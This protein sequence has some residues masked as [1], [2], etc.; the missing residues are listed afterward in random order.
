MYDQPKQCEFVPC[1]ND[2]GGDVVDLDANGLDD[3]G[4]HKDLGAAR[5]VHAR[6]EIRT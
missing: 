1:L 5:R 2:E 3:A 6:T 4:G